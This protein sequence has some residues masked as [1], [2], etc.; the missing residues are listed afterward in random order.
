MFFARRFASSEN[1]EFGVGA[2]FH[3]LEISAFI[4][5]NVIINGGANQ[6]RRESVSAEAPLPNIGVWYMPSFSPKW[7]F[8]SRLD[9]FGADIGD[10]DGTLINAS[11]GLN[12]QVFEHVGIGLDYNYVDLDIGVDKSGWRGEFNTNYSGPYA[13]FSFFW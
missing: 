2:G 11:V 9:W 7:A 12:Y 4:E 13:Y 5:G 3:W 6:F 10:Y 8:K 1:D